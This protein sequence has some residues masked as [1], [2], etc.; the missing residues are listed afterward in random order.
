LSI[1]NPTKGEWSAG[2][3]VEKYTFAAECAAAVGGRTI[4]LETRWDSQH[5]MYLVNDGLRTMAAIYFPPGELS[6][7]API[8]ERHE[9]FWSWDKHREATVAPLVQ[10]PVD[11]AAVDDCFWIL[12]A[13]GGLTATGDGQSFAGPF[14]VAGG[15]KSMCLTEKA[16][17]VASGQEIV[18]VP[19]KRLAEML[20]RPGAFRTSQEVLA[21]ATARLKKWIEAQPPAEQVGYFSRIGRA[22]LALPVLVAQPGTAA[23][24]VVPIVCDAAWQ[25]IDAQR[26]DEAL[27]V[28]GPY[29]S[30]WK[31]LANDDLASPYL[32][33]LRHAE[34]WDRLREF[35]P[36]LWQRTSLADN[37]ALRAYVVVQIRTRENAY[38][39]AVQAT[40]SKQEF[41]KILWDH[42]KGRL[43]EAPWRWTDNPVAGYWGQEVRRVAAAWLREHLAKEGRLQ[44]IEGHPLIPDD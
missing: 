12:D 9:V 37:A 11:V 28:L 10:H 39:A 34:K 26:Y 5:P 7:F 41:E 23:A 17:A 18:I 38:F 24:T 25:W 21:T 40:A 15:A 29:V 22:D 8:L 44:E 2:L 4:L 31:N 27:A 16:L 6:A 20:G 14:M 1:F 30:D 36:Q 42:L 3:S 33:A 43:P 13:A 19:R 32:V 35:V